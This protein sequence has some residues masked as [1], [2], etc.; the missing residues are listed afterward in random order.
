L[1]LN[2][3]YQLFVTDQE[4][5]RDVFGEEL[6][7]FCRKFTRKRSN[8]AAGITSESSWASSEDAA[9]SA[10][11]DV[12]EHLDRYD[13]MRGVQFDTWVGSVVKNYL[14]K[15]YREHKN[16]AQ[17]LPTEDVLGHNPHIG[18]EAKLSVKKLLSQLSDVDKAFVQ[19]KLEGYS[20]EEMAV[21]FGQN[22]QWCWN[23][24]HRIQNILK[25]KAS[26][27]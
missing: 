11:A 22:P 10:I 1:T 8:D 26:S 7:K 18:I 2:E 23:K 24:W 15:A 3:A 5:Y 14:Y 21:H 9:Q 13:S 6:V 25:E 19:M 12:W 16:H 17:I 20:V 27:G 4:Q